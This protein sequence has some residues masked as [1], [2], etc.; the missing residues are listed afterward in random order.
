VPSGGGDLDPADLRAACAERL[1]R[2]K[3]P[4]YLMVRPEPLPQLPNGKLDRV[5][6]RAAIDL[7]RAWDATAG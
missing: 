2:W 5:R 6:L 3:L 4:R 7:E 1:A